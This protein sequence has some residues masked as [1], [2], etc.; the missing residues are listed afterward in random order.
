MID[1]AGAR[2]VPDPDHHTKTRVVADLQIMIGADHQ[3]IALSIPDLAQDLHPEE[4]HDPDP[5]PHIKP[6][7]HPLIKL[8]YKCGINSTA[9]VLSLNLSS[10]VML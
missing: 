7:Q 6:P 3:H 9:G 10:F 4:L 2:L 1:T 5:D 8:G